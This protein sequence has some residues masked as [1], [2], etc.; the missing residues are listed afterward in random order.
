M[1]TIYTVWYFKSQE[2]IETVII[3]SDESE[4]RRI[5]MQ[6]LEGPVKLFRVSEFFKINEEYKK[7]LTLLERLMN[8][9]R[10]GYG[11]KR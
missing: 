5:A 2:D 10:Q 4:A 7:Y 6:K 11:D 1:D 9:D 3:A 8:L